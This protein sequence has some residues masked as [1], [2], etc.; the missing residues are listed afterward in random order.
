MKTTNL[1]LK[2]KFID[3]QKVIII[4]SIFILGIIQPLFAQDHSL[5]NSSFE[6]YNTIPTHHSMFNNCVK[7][8]EN[9]LPIGVSTPDFYVKSANANF[10]GWQTVYESV[11]VKDPN[12]FHGCAYA[13]IFLN[14][15]NRVNSPKFKEYFLQKIDL[16]A[17]HKYKVSIDM[18][19]SIDST[20]DNLEFD[21]GIYGYVGTIPAANI[22]Y[23]V[24]QADGSL[25]P[26]LASISKDSI[27]YDL[28]H[29]TVEFIP[30][31]NASYIM[32][33]GTGCGIDALQNGYVFIDNITLS[34][35][36]E[37]VLNPNVTYLSGE[38]RGCCFTKN[39]EAFQLIGNLP[40]NTSI[41]T[42]WQQ[43]F[44]NPEMVTFANDS[45]FSTG[46]LGSGFLTPG[47]YVFYYSFI[48]GS[49][50]AT[51]TFKV[52][53]N[54]ALNIHAGVD[55][56]R[57][58]TNSIAANMPNYN[59]V[60]GLNAVTFNAT[61]DYT[62]INNNQY[63]SWWSMIRSDGT[64]WVFPNY[65]VAYDGLNEGSVYVE[66]DLYYFGIPSNTNNQGILTN[67]GLKNKNPGYH[68][69]NTFWIAN[70]QD[71]IQFIWHIKDLCENIFTDTLLVVQNRVS[72]EAPVTKCMGDTVLVYQYSDAFINTLTNSPN[73]RYQ[74][75]NDRGNITYLNSTTRSD[76]I[77]FVINSDSN[78]QIRLTVTDTI[79]G[80]IFYCE[81][82]IIVR[83][84]NFTA[85]VNQIRLNSECASADFKLEALPCV[86]DINTREYQTWWSMVRN[87]GSE[88]IF[89]NYC[90]PFNGLDEGS[91]YVD[92]NR[93]I[94]ATPSLTCSQGLLELSGQAYKNPGWHPN[95]SFVLR[96]PQDSVL[97]IWHIKDKCGHLYKDSVLIVQNRVN[98]TAENTCNDNVIMN[99]GDSILFFQLVDSN[100]YKITSRDQ[101]G[102][103]WTKVSGP[104]AVDFMRPI[105]SIDS[106]KIGFTTAGEYIIRLTVYDSINANH[107][108]CDK[109]VYIKTIPFAN[110][111]ID[112][113]ICNDSSTAIFTLNALANVDDINNNC[114]QSWWS[115]IRDN[116]TE[117]VFPNY[118]VPF[119][120]LNEGTVSME[121][122]RFYAPAPTTTCS[123]KKLFRANF[124]YKN[125]GWHPN[126]KVVFRNYGIKKF[127]WH[128]KDATTGVIVT[129]TVILSW[130][131]N[132]TTNAP[133]LDIHPLCNTTFITGE[134]S[135]ASGGIG[136]DYNWRQ[137]SGPMTLETS[138]TNRNGLYIYNLDSA[139]VGIYTFEY[140]KG[141]YA[142]FA[143]DTVDVIIDSHIINS[144]TIL[145]N[146]TYDGHLICYG[147]T[148][149]VSASGGV[150]Y[151]FLVNGIIIQDFS[152]NN[153]F[154][155]AGFTDS[156]IIDVISILSSDGCLSRGINPI[157]VNVNYV[158]LP[159]L[160]LSSND[161]CLGDSIALIATC[162]INNKIKWYTQRNITTALPING[163]EYTSNLEA[164][165]VHPITSTTYY[166]IAF[167]ST[168]GCTSVMDSIKINVH[169][170]PT[171]SSTA[172]PKV[173]CAPG[174]TSSLVGR[175]LQANTIIKWYDNPYRSGS[176]LNIGGT[177]PGVMFNYYF[178]TSDTVYAF[179][180]NTLTG[181]VSSYSMQII[182]VNTVPSLAAFVDDTLEI[183]EYSRVNLTPS[184]IP[185]IA[186]SNIKWY[187][188][189]ISSASYITTRLAYN[190]TPIESGYI[191]AVPTFAGC[192]GLNYDSI[193]IQLSSLPTNPPAIQI[194][195][196]SICRGTTVT[197]SIDS[198]PTNCIA[199]WYYGATSIDTG[200][201]ID[202]AP[203]NTS[204][205]HVY[206]V[207]QL[208]GCQSELFSQ[209]MIH[210]NPKPNAGPD[211]TICQNSTIRL[212]A[213]GIGTWSASALNPSIV[214][215][216]NLNLPTTLVDGF[217]N[218]GYYQLYWTNA[219]GCSDTMQVTVK[220][221]PNTGANL[222]I[223]NNE[224]P[225]LINLSSTSGNWAAQAGNPTGGTIRRIDS[226]S[227]S[228]NYTSVA[229]GIYNYIFSSNGCSDTVAIQVLPKANAGANQHATC[230]INDSIRMN[231]LGTGSWTIASI[232][233]GTA[234][235][236]SI[237]SPTSIIKDFSTPG[238]YYL[239]WNNSICE[240]TAL[241]S[242]SDS[243][244]PEVISNTI[245]Q[246]INDI[247]INNEMLLITGDSA[248]PTS[249]IYQWL[250][251]DG[252][253]YT[254][255]PGVSNN[256]NYNFYFNS[257]GTFQFIRLYTTISG[258][259]FTDTSNM[260]RISIHADDTTY[261]TETVCYG[262]SGN[263]NF[264]D[265]THSGITTL[266][267]TN[268]YGC[269]STINITVNILPIHTSSITIISCNN[270]QLSNQ[271]VQTSGVYHDTIL[272]SAGCDSIITYNITILYSDTNII[273]AVICNNYDY[274]FNNQYLT[275][276]GT[277]YDTMVSS[278]GCD[279][280]IILNLEVRYPMYKQL[281]ATICEGD[282]F[283]FGVHTYDVEGTYID[284][285]IRVNGCDSITYI[286]L[287]V[288][289]RLDTTLT[290]TSCAG[291][292]I[293][294][295]GHNYT[296]S[297]VY[298]DTLTAS[299]GCDSL[300]TLNINILIADTTFITMTS[301]NTVN[302]NGQTF[303]TSTTYIDT[304]TT[305]NGCDSI[306]T[307][308]ITILHNDTNIIEAVIC[309]NYDYYFNDQYLTD[310]GTYYDTMV[311][312]NGCDSIIILNLE[313]RYP[314]YKQLS[315]TICEG[316][317]FTFGI[318]TYN[319]EGTYID[320]N[321]RVNGCDSI[322][323]ITLF[324]IP[325]LDTIL[326]F[327]SCAGNPINFNG[328]NYTSSGV[329]FDTLT[330]ST[331]CDSLVTLNINILFADTTS[332]TMTSCNTVN[333]NGQTFLTSTIYI[334]TQTSI[335]GCDSVII[336]QIVIK[337]NDTTFLNASICNKYAYNFNGQSI[338]IAG[339]YA[340]T[341]TSFNGC[342]SI[343]LLTIDVVYPVFHQVTETICSNEIFYYG[344]HTYN[345]EGTYID[346]ILGSN[347][348]DSITYIT[349]FVLPSI[350]SNLYFTTCLGNS[351]NINNQSYNAEGDYNDTLS[352]YNGCDSIL[353]IHMH[354]LNP[355][356]SSTNYAIC[357][358]ASI[359]IGES[360][361]SSTG[362]YYDTLST[363][364][365][366]D[367]IIKTIISILTASTE[368]SYE[369][370][371]AGSEVH[372]VIV[373]NDTIL[374]DTLFSIYHCDSVYLIVHVDVT[375]LPP[376]EVSGDTNVCVGKNI[377]LE[378]SGGNNTFIWVRI[379]SQDNN[380]L[381]K[382]DTIYYGNQYDVTPIEDMYLKVYN[383]DCSYRVNYKFITVYV[384]PIPTIEIQN[385]D[386]CLY[387]GQYLQ[388]T[389]QHSNGSDISWSN[390]RGVICANCETLKF[391][392][393]MEST[394]FVTIKDSIGCLALDS[395][396]VC[397]NDECNDSTIEIPNIITANQD[398]I[399]D[400]FYIKNPD[401]I[402]IVYTKIYDRWGMEM[403]SSNEQEPKWDGTF[404]GEKCNSGV[405]A[406]VI[407][408][409]CQKRT[410]IVK[411][412]NISIIK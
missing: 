261:I 390:E 382:E 224:L 223:C 111:G 323:Y 243:C 72:L 82:T 185:F 219:S 384:N 198:I 27:T 397:I 83:L 411:S 310:A 97:F 91:V 400:L 234:T 55:L 140:R 28:K 115:M 144:S 134:L 248:L 328:H 225:I 174:G 24:T 394:V 231:A 33:G 80:A 308:N 48:N 329:Y 113:N 109:T 352:S 49:E 186:G 335:N 1:Y 87:D 399:N 393:I 300:V 330:A 177:L 338:Y 383:Y 178:T 59:P 316:D 63:L 41:Q 123:Q 204:N 311:S 169:P 23:C 110:A 171:I 364:N 370:V 51:D 11:K 14:Y 376:F 301:C 274:Y 145:L 242:V 163:P 5:T 373:N 38:T 85:G 104:S 258:Y 187:N 130:S 366:C 7:V 81:K 9:A 90:V 320:S 156:S 184:L 180:E 127:I 141:R 321:I 273:E 270:F 86:S 241:I 191:Y 10:T 125:P 271:T 151:A 149:C 403:Y 181:C 381:V 360:N 25:A 285:N 78:I 356:T 99:V 211:K 324:V 369:S 238:I 267:Y 195:N 401:N 228:V 404:N 8:W 84:E 353:H 395:F 215:I 253:T 106:M 309:N 32:F 133:M 275:D 247:C 303:L 122:N 375:S 236:D 249:G 74:W 60:C 379:Y 278:N 322:T 88:W 287:F 176:P 31:Q 387:Y 39:K 79:T 252:T 349:L 30:T 222:A 124:S 193:F 385:T 313:V 314:M 351:I 380:G 213:S 293:Y 269:D 16:V 46:I 290:F 239:I 227:A 120:G 341:F 118:C 337:D 359:H 260:I 233:S 152:T 44:A 304:Q 162:N 160:I 138:D 108:Y 143:Y 406:Y 4:L 389:T 350:D 251:S 340:D 116:G 67:L 284:S 29:F 246:P 89:P 327:T 207:N 103:M 220:M 61:P 396:N 250:I 402:P 357:A 167:D 332:I 268:L 64:E 297:G 166:F 343:V 139:T 276:A 336:Y 257:T 361:Y 168:T 13:G 412:G 378:A 339:Q 298:F 409:R 331:G 306:I 295:N 76:S 299:T 128:V 153:T 372:G 254:T 245:H 17:G 132:E 173:F 77:L 165:Y 154:C 282:I 217:L 212:S 192:L 334:D 263:F 58:N 272:S 54:P 158:A 179:A 56:I 354:I 150:Q 2:F 15:N 218:N 3:Y 232:S 277:Y 398:G 65:A 296:S 348:C 371:C 265:Y 102:F 214:N 172:N 410:N 237:N 170:N 291:N 52:N 94:G 73:L 142:C 57:L 281:S 305:I 240:D 35:S 202:I 66:D 131:Y 355:I 368:T 6:Y 21:L 347:G 255:A 326:T 92:S 147:D 365:G 362:V 183:C 302:I 230:Y 117:W 161:I 292:P 137:I 121:N 342:D 107:F 126:N 12:Q 129:D 50:I 68:P 262:N 119:N 95:N 358:G 386:T 182:K 18:S 34:D 210:V 345:E 100:I 159:N 235:I 199:V 47:S 194:S 101:L 146:T 288:I 317:I 19:K 75:R 266:N 374:M 98:I 155:Y 42:Y 289:P 69:N 318:H 216:D 405:Y 279:S 62:T 344:Y 325:R 200:N 148:V 190:F 135:G 70:A 280:I 26:L 244:Y 201:S 407:E 264:I 221:K 392:A 408:A 333:I 315:A 312:S 45:N 388:L 164:F 259:I 203:F 346:T 377:I 114:F 226:I 283:T 93:Y 157:H 294:F 229:N 209:V 112:Q 256:Q 136:S 96:N 196:D 37:E 197:L 40:Q 206:F 36:L 319:E 105:T 188:D 363:Y 189:S 286:T 22:N 20:S 53:V 391:Q 367:S 175:C 71:S 307:Y 205:Y 43:D 208:T